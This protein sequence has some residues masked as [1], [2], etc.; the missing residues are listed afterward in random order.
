MGELEEEIVLV[1]REDNV[2]STDKKLNCHTGEGEL[3]RG[4]EIFLFDNLGRL[5][6]QKRN[7]KKLTWP[8]YWDGTAG[9]PRLSESY[10]EAGKRRLEEELGIS[11]E[12]SKAFTFRYHATYGKY[13]EQ[14]VCALLHGHSDE[15]LVINLDEVSEVNYIH[16]DELRKDIEQN[17]EKYTPWFKIAF[18][19]YWNG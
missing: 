11:A 4:L 3:H 10:E 9:H 1:D 12:L 16:L 15:P 19:K 5:L 8:H 14:E 17:P 6:I 13:T 2:I 7:G 18:D